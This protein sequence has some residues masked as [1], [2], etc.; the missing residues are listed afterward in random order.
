MLN[1]DVIL[2][3]D[4]LTRE[5]VLVPEWGGT[6]HVRTMTGM[7]GESYEEACL[8]ATQDGRTDIK[9]MRVRLLLM[10][11]CDEKGN[12]LFA[13]EDADVLSAKSAAA[14]DRLFQVALR[15]NGLTEEAVKEQEG[16]SS[17]DHGSNSGSS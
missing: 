9:G 4:D 7:E 15:I 8:A 1:R 13:A 5:E 16:N 3:A 17:G 12:C 14:L 6:V 2:Q 11:L 10:T